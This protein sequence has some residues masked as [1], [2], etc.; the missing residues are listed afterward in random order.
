MSAFDPLRTLALLL[1]SAASGGFMH[2][3]LGKTNYQRDAGLAHV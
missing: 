1:A 2:Y 3:H